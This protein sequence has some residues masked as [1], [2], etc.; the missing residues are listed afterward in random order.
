MSELEVQSASTY[1]V[2]TMPSKT[3]NLECNTEAIVTQ[4]VETILISIRVTTI[5]NQ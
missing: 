5:Q 3:K 4:K 2:V 1:T